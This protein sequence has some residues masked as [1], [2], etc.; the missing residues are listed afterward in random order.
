VSPVLAL[1]DVCKEVVGIISILVYLP[2]CTNERVSGLAWQT[3]EF[4]PAVDGIIGFELVM[5]NG[6]FVNVT[7]KTERDLFWALK[8]MHRTVLSYL[9]TFD[10]DNISA[11]REL[12]ITL[13]LLHVTP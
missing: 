6:T 13:A 9:Y 8:V 3:S 12:E 7:E 10:I 4:G 2:S 1:V 5:P 11:L